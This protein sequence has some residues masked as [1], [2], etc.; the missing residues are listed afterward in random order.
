M[1]LALNLYFY[2]T[3]TLSFAQVKD[4]HRFYCF[5]YGIA[6]ECGAG[7]GLIGLD[8]VMCNGTESTLSECPNSGWGVHNCGH[9]QDAACRC[10]YSNGPNV[11]HCNGKRHPDMIQLHGCQVLM[12]K[13]AHIKEKIKR[14]S[15]E[16]RPCK[17]NLMRIIMKAV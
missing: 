9:D 8:D 15:N 10:Y 14:K 11:T 2:T 3:I 13:Q 7:S 4:A 16:K 12:Q 6:I 17:F 1:L 5:S